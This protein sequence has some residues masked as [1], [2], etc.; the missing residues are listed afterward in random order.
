MSITLED[1]KPKQFKINIR[2][3]E[4]VCNPPRLSHALIL[5]K[6]G[7]VFKEART[8]TKEQFKQAEI[9]FDEV[10][11]ELAPELKEIKFDVS[12]AMDIISEILEHIQPSDNKALKE[13]GVELNSPKVKEAGL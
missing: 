1:L 4:T 11:G 13:A 2:G 10:V 6:V 3:Y 9:D 5:T 8:A 12:V 7:E